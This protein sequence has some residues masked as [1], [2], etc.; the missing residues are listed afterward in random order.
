MHFILTTQRPK[1]TLNTILSR[2]QK[3]FFSPLS[4][5][6]MHTLLTRPRSAQV[7]AHQGALSVEAVHT[8][9]QLSGGSMSEALH[10]LN[11]NSADEGEGV[12]QGPEDQGARWLA[13]FNAQLLSLIR[14]FDLTG[15]A[16]ALLQAWREIKAYEANS[17]RDEL[18][19][20]LRLLRAWYRDVLIFKELPSPAPELLT[21]PSLSEHT[22]ARAADLSAEQLRWRLQ[23]L[24][25]AE[26]D[27]FERTGAN[28][29]LTLKAL[30]MYLAG[31]DAVIG[32]PL[33]PHR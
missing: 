16:E 7:G 2:C 22:W 28:R 18:R 15:G 3:L 17:K 11:L 21:Y 9:A 30:S 1:A 29:A 5:E 25:D 23:A 20:L 33:Y 27:L 10:W 6:V 12:E 26:R 31:F 4:V 13:R 32:E 24:Q 19:R 8:L 14:T